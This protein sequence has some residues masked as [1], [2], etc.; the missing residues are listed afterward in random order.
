M[1]AQAP[2]GVIHD[3]MNDLS[4]LAVAIGMGASL[5]RVGFEDSVFYANG[6]IAN[7]NV[8]IVHKLVLLIKQMGFDTATPQEARSILGVK[9]L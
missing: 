9:P 1:T 5:V 3:G 8:E 2:W 7:T 4:L 6:K